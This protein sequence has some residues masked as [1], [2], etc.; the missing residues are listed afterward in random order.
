M[1]DIQTAVAQMM[2]CANLWVLKP[3]CGDKKILNFK[4]KPVQPF[5]PHIYLTKVVFLPCCL[6]SESFISGSYPVPKCKTT[7]QLQWDSWGLK[8]SAQMHFYSSW[9][10]SALLSTSETVTCLKQL[11]LAQNDVT[12]KWYTVAFYS[13][14]VI[15]F[16]YRMYTLDKSFC[17]PQRPL[18]I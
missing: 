1:T 12:V 4:K 17:L 15:C 5:E 9:N 2:G 18:S 10:L 7:E 16:L 3:M 8:D 14:S 13:D 11:A 6:I